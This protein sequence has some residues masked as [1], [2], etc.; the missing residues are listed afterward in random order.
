MDLN[1]YLASVAGAFALLLKF[2][3]NGSL[4]PNV[5]RVINEEWARSTT[6]RFLSAAIFV[7]FGGMV[8]VF[9][10]QPSTVP[11]AVAA[12]LGWTGLISISGPD[13]GGR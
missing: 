3:S 10:I 5:F 6:A 7:I 12:G 4:P 9:M 8:A 2:A 1:L 11:Q 13:G